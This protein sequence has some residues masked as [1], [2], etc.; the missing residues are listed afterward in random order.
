MQ[1]GYRG[2]RVLCKTARVEKDRFCLCGN[3]GSVWTPSPST[4]AFG[5]G[6]P[7]R[8]GE[9]YFRAAQASWMRVQAFFSTSSDVA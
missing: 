2:S 1:R 4:I 7:P 5:D 6:P 9:D 3:R 8:A